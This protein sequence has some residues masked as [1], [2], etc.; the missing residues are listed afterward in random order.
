MIFSILYFKFFSRNFA[1]KNNNLKSTTMGLMDDIKA[2]ITND[3]VEALL[4]TEQAQKMMKMADPFVKPALKA[5]LKE[6]GKDE[7]RFMMYY[8]LETDK[9]VFLTIKTANLTQFEVEGI[10]MDKDVFVIDPHEIKKGNVKDV[11]KT[12]IKKIGM[13]FM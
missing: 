3:S 6:L 13:K 4:E 2:D 7:K 8:D 9:L 1:K 11:I 5:L 12:I 10:D